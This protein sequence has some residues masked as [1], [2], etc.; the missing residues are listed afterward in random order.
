M[1]VSHLDSFMFPQD[2]NAPAKAQA[3]AELI[4]DPELQVRFNNLK[5]SIPLRTD[6]D[7]GQLDDFLK[8]NVEHLNN[9]DQFPRTLAH[10]LACTP[11]E[12]DAYKD[13]MANN[14]SD[15]YNAE[16]TAEALMAV[17]E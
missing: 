12:L 6:I 15:P 9:H 10:G 4:G 5:G 3:F 14:F 17:F 7:D 1:Y 2:G 8:M 16:A 11:E 13:A